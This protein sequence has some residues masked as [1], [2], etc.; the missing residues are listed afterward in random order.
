MEQAEQVRL[1]KCRGAELVA[2]KTEENQGTYGNLQDLTGNHRRETCRKSW[3]MDGCQIIWLPHGSWGNHTTHLGSEP[4]S[5]I[6]T[7]RLLGTRAS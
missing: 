5:F 2:V 6:R 4:N 1:I 3:N 7:F